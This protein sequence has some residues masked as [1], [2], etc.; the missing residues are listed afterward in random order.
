MA[1]HRSLPHLGTEQYRGDDLHSGRGEGTRPWAAHVVSSKSNEG[2]GVPWK[3]ARTVLS[4]KWNTLLPCGAQVAIVVQMRS[5]QRRPASLRLPCVI[6]R[7]IT[8]KRIACF[9]SETV[10]RYL[11]S[12]LGGCE[13]VVDRVIT[14][15]RLKAARPK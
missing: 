13:F 4:M 2:H 8:T 11:F 3:K 1:V 6:F 14:F 5:N 7:S 9:S 15:N 10:N 12:I